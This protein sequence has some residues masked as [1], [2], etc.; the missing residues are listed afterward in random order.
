MNMILITITKTQL[1]SFDSWNM[2]YQSLKFCNSY[3]LKNFTLIKALFFLLNRFCL[4]YAVSFFLWFFNPMTTEATHNSCSFQIKCSVQI[5][6]ILTILIILKLLQRL[7]LTFAYL[8]IFFFLFC[9]TFWPFTYAIY[10]EHSLTVDISSWE[11]VKEQMW[12]QP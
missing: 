10:A 2:R 3:L 7:F 11:K 1:L 8:R 4:S 6:T 5:L 9:R 12:Q